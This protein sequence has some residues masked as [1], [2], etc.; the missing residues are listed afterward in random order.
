MKTCVMCRKEID[1]EADLCPFCRTETKYNFLI[2]IPRDQISLI[3][4]PYS[5]ALGML[6]VVIF[7][8]AGGFLLYLFFSNVFIG[9][10]GLVAGY[11]LG[12]TIFSNAITGNDEVIVNC[13]QCQRTYKH[14]SEGRALSLGNA[15]LFNCPTCNKITSIKAE[16]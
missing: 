1:K 2:T 4:S 10:C 16:M 14:Q 13:P 9:L 3:R 8:I 5:A 15:E 12:A 6:M 7:T 11:K